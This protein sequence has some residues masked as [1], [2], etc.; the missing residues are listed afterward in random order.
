MGL[1]PRYPHELSHRDWTVLLC[2]PDGR[3][4][5]DDG[6]GLFHHDCRLLSSYRLT[7]DGAQ[8]EWVSSS[9]DESDAW[10]TSLRV[11]CEGG[12]AEGPALPQDALELRLR[13][14]LRDGMTEWLEVR[15]HGMTSREVTL[16]LALAADFAD[17]LEVATEHRQQQ[18]TARAERAEADAIELHYDAERRRRRTERGLRIRAADGQ[19]AW[20]MTPG[21]DGASAELTVSLSLEARGRWTAQLVYEPLVDGR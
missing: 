15:N 3:I 11:A 19:V 1:D 20:R 2:H 17:V 10:S 14:L 18:G 9:A 5:G 16:E 7:I 4:L 12:T 13:R 8:P 6:C 21:R